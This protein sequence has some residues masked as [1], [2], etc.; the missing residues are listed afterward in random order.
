MPDI[1]KDEDDYTEDDRVEKPAAPLPFRI[2]GKTL[3]WC[4]WL[5]IFAIN[6]IILW[7]MFSSG[8]PASVKTVEGNTILAEAYEEYE[9]AADKSYPFAIYQRGHTT[10]TDQKADKTAG[11]SGNYGYF[12]ITQSVIFPTASQAQI[13]FRYNNSTLEHVAEDYDLNEKPAKKDESF[14]LS[15]RVVTEDGEIKRIYPSG[16][17]EAYKTLYSYRRLTFDGLPEGLAGVR[18]VYLDV[19][20]I[21]DVNYDKDAYG[22]LCIYSVD[23][24]N[25]E[26]DLT[27]ND[28]SAIKKGKDR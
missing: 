17:I 25:S 20:Y 27:K 14:D 11:T 22:S 19:Y 12:A 4:F 7:R 15:L 28:V 9:S 26:Y 18:E 1:F 16:S 8:D 13:V 6:A 23:Y 2:L 24:K 10:I 3:K 21:N 5:V